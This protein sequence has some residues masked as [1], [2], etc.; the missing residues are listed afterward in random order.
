[1]RSV[2]R[3]IMM[4]QYVIGHTQVLMHANMK[5]GQG[6]R[7]RMILGRNNFYHNSCIRQALR[8][9]ELWRNGALIK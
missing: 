3:S 1:M 8:V 2:K 5:L 9:E 4:W 6:V 7:I